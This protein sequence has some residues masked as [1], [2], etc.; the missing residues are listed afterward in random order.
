MQICCMSFGSLWWLR[1]GDQV[2]DPQRFVSKAAIFNTTGFATGSKERRL[3]HVAGV[4]RMNA[5]MHQEARS[6]EAFEGHSFETVGLEHRGEWNRLLLKRR[7]AARQPSGLI[8]LCVR[9]RDEGRI[10]FDR[11]WH[12]P[13]VRVVA[14][15]A[16]RGDQETLLMAEV[17]S[18]IRTQKGEWEVTWQGLAS[19]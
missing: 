5:G 18:T 17:G 6:K 12:S 13:G 19:R 10:N 15:S 11:E 9:S 16:F 3:W 7:I 1:P 14:A 4:V 8:L 2:G